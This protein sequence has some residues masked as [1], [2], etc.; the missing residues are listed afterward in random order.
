MT[1]DRIRKLLPPVLV[2][3]GT[4]LLL[5]LVYGP[6]YLNYD[7]SYSLVW[8]QD[9]AHGRTP[10]YVG[11]I[12]PT[13]HPL[14][15][16]ISYLA[17]PLGGAAEPA[18]AWGV[19]LCFGVIVWLVYLLGRDLLNNWVG[20][21]AAIVVL[22]R[23]AFDRNALATYQDI[24]FVMFVIWALVLEV[25][26]P[27]RGWPVLA[28]LSLAG[29]LRPEAWVL[30]GLYWLYLFPARTWKE[31]IWLAV[32][33]ASGPVLWA[34][35]D[36][37]VTG[38]LLHSLHGTSDL[39]A[40]LDRPRQPEEAPLWTLRFFGFTLREP[41]IL[42]VPIGCAYLWFCAR[43]EF[44]ILLGVAAIMTGVFML[45]T[46]AGLPLIARYV[47]TP[48]IVLAVVYAAGVF[49]WRSLPDD[50]PRKQMW[51]W[52]GVASLALSIVWIPWHINVVNET[53]QKVENYETI[54]TAL[55]NFADDPRVVRFNE[56]CGRISTT[57]HR[58]V[59]AFRYEL[60]GA[61]NSVQSDNK[62]SGYPLAEL[63]LYPASR[64]VANRF[65]ST[66]PDLTAPKN[67]D[68]EAYVVVA[69][70]WAWKLYAS[71][72]CVAAVKQGKPS[73]GAK[74]N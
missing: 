51:K 32:L 60:D 46:I 15:T 13:P 44:K 59:P 14:Q 3:L 7:A 39:A 45:T 5:W 11:F 41:L 53:R 42:G 74:P 6:P 54:S 48:T 52:I 38:D 69:S 47:L 12:A 30:A 64:D 16:L 63:A 9:I 21:L 68:G 70:N 31:R 67:A 25:R 58:P 34:I 40:L 4:P 36:W 33:T 17:L 2:I 65:Y 49:G 43:R 62:L 23:P 8:A 18:L 37:A 29:L 28:L 24:P 73:A 71:P 72:D 26:Q 56:L 66:I 19:M 1:G 20:A 27:R 10:D 57:D 35:S 61:P 50:F 22:T 55:R